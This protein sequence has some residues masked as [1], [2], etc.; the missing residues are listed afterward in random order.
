MTTPSSRPATRCLAIVSAMAVGLIT[1]SGAAA[2]PVGA[3][4]SA[5]WQGEAAAVA[6]EAAKLIQ[7]QRLPEAL[8]I[9]DRAIGSDPD[10]WEAHYQRGR[11]LALLGRMEEARDALLRA[12]ELNPGFEHGHYLAWLAA[13]RLQEYDTAWEQAISAE[14]AGT[15][16]SDRFAEM[17]AYTEAPE[18]ILDRLGAPRIF[19]APFDTEDVEGGAELPYNRN[20]MVEENRI[21]TR[22]DVIQGTFRLQEATPEL[23]SL[24]RELRLAIQRAPYLGLTL[25]PRGANVYVVLRI[26]VLGERAPRRLEGALQALDVESGNVRWH[27]NIVLTDISSLGSVMPEIERHVIEMQGALRYRAE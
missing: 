26:D 21:S 13:M 24:H 10:Y 17:L 6:D 5:G 12:V 18:D 1:A 11:A 27:R 15:D 20:P 16:M 14:L 25:E 7:E 3:L 2:G 22:P 9:L 23:L 4:G 19:V 8:E